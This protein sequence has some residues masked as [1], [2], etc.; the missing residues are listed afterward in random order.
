MEE[1][2]RRRRRRRRGRRTDKM[3]RKKT[4]NQLMISFL[5]FHFFEDIEER[6]SENRSREKAKRSRRTGIGKED[7]LIIQSIKV[8]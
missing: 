8:I 5:S 3:R 6:I 4:K 2:W 7:C 1:A